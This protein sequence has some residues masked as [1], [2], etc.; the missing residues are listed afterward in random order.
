MNSC[1]G[2][3]FRYLPAMPAKQVTAL[4][5]G[6]T[7]IAGHVPV[8]QTN[9]IA[10]KV[11]DLRPPRRRTPWLDRRPPPEPASSAR[12]PCT[13][14]IGGRNGTSSIALRKATFIS[15]RGVLAISCKGGRRPVPIP[16]GTTLGHPRVLLHL[17]SSCDSQRTC[18]EFG[19]RTDWHQ[20]TAG[21][22]W[23]GW[24]NRSYERG[25]GTMGQGG[26][27][28]TWRRG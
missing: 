22:A 15:R 9:M 6:L 18:I 7:A 8:P 17:S 24:G 27:A 2:S 23:K 25:G 10:V 5:G 11:H 21:P 19:A 20:A 14:S 4:T 28:G 12:S 3:I 26:G 16:A 13:F 1:C